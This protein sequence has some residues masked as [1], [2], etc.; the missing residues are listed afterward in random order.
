MDAVDA[1]FQVAL[2]LTSILIVLGLESLRKPRLHFTIGQ[3]GEIFPN[4]S[5][6]RTPGRWLHVYVYNSPMPS[7]LAWAFNRSPALSCRGSIDFRD[8]RGQ[9]MFDKPMPLRWANNPE[10]LLLDPATGKPHGIDWDKM[11]TGHLWDITPGLVAERD[12]GVAD[13][14]FRA[15][16]EQECYGWNNDSYL[17]DW[18]NP[19]WKLPQGR[20]F[21]KLVVRT[22][23]QSFSET[24]L[25]SNDGSYRDFRLEASPTHHSRS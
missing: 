24:F 6:G 12:Y 21:A 9:E 22:G 17:H 4:D 19:Q 10:P 23:G 1:F 25:V 3:P 13:V 7:W 16:S 8:S 2:T 11:R 18:R 20:Y 15:A 14:V 5:L